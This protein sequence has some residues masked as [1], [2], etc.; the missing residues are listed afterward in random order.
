M[1]LRAG[2]G[3]RFHLDVVAPTLRTMSWMMVKVVR[4][5]FLPAASPGRFFGP[6]AVRQESARSRIKNLMPAKM[7]GTI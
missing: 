7:P 2:L 5:F 3:D 1:D 4:T 6:Q